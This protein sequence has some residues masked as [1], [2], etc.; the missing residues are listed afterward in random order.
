[1]VFGETEDVIK[2]ENAPPHNCHK[3][4]SDLEL[5]SLNGKTPPSS[6][7]D[8]CQLELKAEREN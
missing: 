4:W 2:T 5:S 3:R 6:M 1:M 8:K 7:Q